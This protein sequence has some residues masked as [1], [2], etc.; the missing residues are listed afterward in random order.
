MRSDQRRRELKLENSSPLLARLRESDGGGVRW[1]FDGTAQI[2]IAMA[3]RHGGFGGNRNP[4]FGIPVLL[5]P[6][7]LLF[8][9]PLNKTASTGGAIVRLELAISSSP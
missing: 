1:V 3:F 6:Q 8:C 7:V 9:S 2:A 5:T 4:S